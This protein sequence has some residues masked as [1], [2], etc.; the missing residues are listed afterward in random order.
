MVCDSC[1]LIELGLVSPIVCVYV[2]L[3]LNH[4]FCFENLNKKCY[5]YCYNCC[6]KSIHS[7]NIQIHPIILR[8]D[9]IETVSSTISE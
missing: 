6:I 1:L 2:I 8:E 5:K 9:D 7:N 4:F 3:T